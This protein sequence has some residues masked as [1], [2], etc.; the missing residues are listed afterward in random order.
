MISI[1][2]VSHS[3]K[4]AEGVCE[5]AAQVAQGRVRLAPCGGTGDAEHPLGTD[6]FRVCDAIES[7]YDSDGVLVL[8]DLGSAV[9][10]AETAHGFLDQDKRPNVKLCAAPLVEGAIAAAALAAAGAS[11]DEIARE[12]FT[13]Q[14]TKSAGA[15][16]PAAERRATLRNPLGLHA[17]PAARLVQMARQFDARVALHNETAGRGPADAASMNALLTL[18]ARQGHTVAVQAEGRQ[19]EEAAAA[20]ASFLE[21]GCGETEAPG[22]VPPAQPAEGPAALDSLRGIGASAGFAVAPLATMR[23]AWRAPAPRQASDPAAEERNL[24]SAIE[25]A[26]GETR[27][28]FD[29]ASIHAGRAHAGI[30]D[31]QAAF[32][33]DPDLAGA[34]L[35][36]IRQGQRPAEQAW[37][38]AGEE[39][40]RRLESLD[41]P[42]LRARAADARDAAAR[43][44][45]H[46]TEA[47][48]V[49][50]AVSVPSIL[51]AREIP[52]SAVKE[53]DPARVLGL[54]LEMGSPSAHGVILARAMGIPAVVGLGPAILSVEE[55]T[56]AALDG[57][58]GLVWIAPN[59]ERRRDIE[60]RRRAWLASRRA[61]D[62]KRSTPATT[63]DGHRIPVFANIS[64]VEE[65]AVAVERGAEGVGVL[66][67]E[68][69]FL[70]RRTPPTEQEQR[71]AYTGIAAAL[72]GRP[73]MIRTLDIGGDKSVP[74]I[75]A[76]EE[77][78]PFLGWRGI[79]LTLERDDLMRTQLRAILRAAAGHP[80]GILL[81]MVASLSEL[82]RAQAMIQEVEADLARDGAPH[83]AGLRPGVMIET[84]ASV[85]I[86]PELA[87]EAAF[88]SIG[89]N[90]LIQYVMAAD[91]TNPRIAVLADPFQPAVL[92][93]VRQAVAAAKDASIPVAVCGEAA[94][95]PLAAPMFIGMGVEELSVSARLIP[96]I[97]GTIAR[98]TLA[99]ARK[100]AARALEL[101]S[102]EAVRRLLTDSLPP[103]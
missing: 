98:W 27:A 102:S 2:I 9:L 61:A 28:L 37:H 20:I 6:A 99:Q 62:A 24:L 32:I 55:G 97:K 49:M 91:R 21:T 42:D 89:T 74:Y 22:E 11:I 15:L 88:F 70:N 46:L 39:I 58:R 73:L 44:L 76:G 67:T 103:G 92:R 13:A 75:D 51:A 18:T 69:L 87:R 60:E 7:V 93:A 100:I 59:D 16:A 101:D 96:E 43:V 57:E 95:D 26:K 90:D 85:A 36:A 84:P 45:S 8:M 81:P 83:R 79:R 5:L 52:P 64:G 17:R 29:W 54:C 14:A 1:V 25:A 41:D 71:A 65:A 48:G 72:A 34:A 56:V 68:F 33:D 78:N 30:F 3:A 35:H 12:A 82:R 63:G 50:A 86:A 38:A 47:S 40:A 77:A 19:A 23:S 53:L 10:S 66:R 94:A 80:I 31:A 4:L